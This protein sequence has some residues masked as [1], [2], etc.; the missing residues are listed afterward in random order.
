MPQSLRTLVRDRLERL[1]HGAR[2]AA[3]VAS[4]LAEPT[5]I[6][7][8]AI[9]GPSGPDDLAAA[10]GAGVM[11]L[12]EGRL[13]LTHPLL[14]SVLQSEV[15]P[16]EGRELHRRLASALT[17]PEERARHLAL[18]TEAPDAG[19]AAILEG[20]ALRAHR[21]GAMEAALELAERARALTPAD[22]GEDARRRATRAAEYHLEG[23]G[24]RS[25]AALLEEVVASSPAGTEKA[26][27]LAR[28]AWAR[29]YIDNRGVADLL[30]AAR[31][32]AGDDA[33][34]R[35]EIDGALAWACHLRGDVPAA[36][37]HARSSLLFAQLD[38]PGALATALADVA[39]LEFVMAGRIH[40]AEMDRA[41]AL[42][43]ASGRLRILGRPSW[44]SGML[45]EYTGDLEGARAALEP[46]YRE[47][48][49]HGDENSIPF[50][51]GHLSRV[52][53][54]AG[55]W[56]LAHRLAEESYEAALQSDQLPERAFSLAARAFVE[57]H[58]G[59][60]D[61]VRATVSEGL[62]LADRTGMLPA[63]L[64]LLASL[65][66][67]ELS[68]GDAEAAHRHQ[69]VAL[70]AMQHAGFG[71][72]AVF[73]VHPNE[74]EAL[75]A[76]GR[77]DEAEALVRELAECGRAHGRA[78]AL[79][80]AARCRALILMARGDRGGAAGAADDGLAR[81]AQLLEPFELARTLLV[82]GAIDRRAKQKRTARGF[83]ERAL[84]IFDE[85]GAALWSERARAALARVGGRAPTSGRLTPTEAQ[86]AA[87]SPP[88]ARTARSPT[89]SS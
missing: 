16:E 53:T 67:L 84:A 15:A 38:D 43:R 74:A 46:R 82:R 80:T 3:L 34:A 51:A 60:V 65:G 73:R 59:R 55:R 9:L 72:P 62:D 54:R 6:I 49:E 17:E 31:A 88:G 71:E 21:R 7:V 42:E 70:R 64:E 57:A 78:W 30:G 26:Q 37:G 13:R 52:E 68:R 19:V 39:L 2:A 56:M 44:I 75:V 12:E 47:A 35:T 41:L 11:T 85:L 89:R 61:D 14:A 79:A 33:A 83:L 36:L 86:V 24:T 23:G 40:P 10:V 4:N 20:E 48:S 27:A 50:I 22:C 45:L 87:L 69:G 66:L 25:A 5:A 1:S 28:L 76:L 58:L 32:E 81:H 18:A 77:L 29:T 8:E 63:R